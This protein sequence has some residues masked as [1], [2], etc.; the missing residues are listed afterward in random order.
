MN[1]V[2]V[3]G[4]GGHGKVVAE[5]IESMGGYRVVGFL[6]DRLDRGHRIGRWT[7]IGGA[8]ALADLVSEGVRAAIVGIGSNETRVGKAELL[9]QHGIA[10]LTAIHASSV[11]SPSARLGA[12]TVAM[13]GVIVNADTVVGDNSILNTGATVDHDC[14][15]GQ[16]CHISPGAHLAGNVSVGSFAHIGI[17]A[18]VIQNIVIGRGAIVGAGAAVIRDVADGATVVG[19]PAVVRTT[20]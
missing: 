8:T 5:V 1:D 19:V 3:Y 20:S 2:F 13:A 18:S 15:I 17:G 9:R 16:G 12:G 6:D 10:L 11:I 7:V 14:R 4:G